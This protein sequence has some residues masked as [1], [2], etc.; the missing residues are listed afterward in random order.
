MYKFWNRNPL[1]HLSHYCDHNFLYT[2]LILVSVSVPT[3]KKIRKIE[4]IIMI[5]YGGVHTH[6][7][8][9]SERDYP[10]L[11]YLFTVVSL[12]RIEVV[13]RLSISTGEYR[14]MRNGPCTHYYRTA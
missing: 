14:A 8:Q 4:S 12:K 11:E 13:F 3:P 2:F 1:L 5:M 10:Q 6:S 9:A 7:E